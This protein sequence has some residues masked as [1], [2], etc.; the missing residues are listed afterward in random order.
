MKSLKEA[1]VSDHVGTDHFEILQL[2]LLVPVL[3][4]ILQYA[5]TGALNQRSVRGL[6]CW[7]YAVIVLPATLSVMVTYLTPL[8]SAV[9]VTAFVLACHQLVTH[10]SGLSQNL[11]QLAEQPRKRWQAYSKFVPSKLSLL[12]IY[13]VCKAVCSYITA[14]RGTTLLCTSICILAV[15]FPA[16]PR[17]YCKAEKFGQGKWLTCHTTLKRNAGVVLHIAMII[18][19]LW[20]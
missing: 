20:C 8:T 18:L 4:F 7:E 9:G 10:E 1:F 15:D 16:F 14:V 11:Q 13:T 12:H 5:H 17:R 3:S 2:V 19:H 6:L